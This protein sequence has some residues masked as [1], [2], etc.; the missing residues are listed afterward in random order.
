MAIIDFFWKNKKQTSFH[1]F[2]SNDDR[3]LA[4]Q[5]YMQDTLISTIAGFLPVPIVISHNADLIKLS[6]RAQNFGPLINI[7]KLK[8]LY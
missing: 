7:F 2:I 5:L 1:S 6:A 3:Y 4:Q 8:P